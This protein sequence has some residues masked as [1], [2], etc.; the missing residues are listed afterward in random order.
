M[1][2]AARATALVPCRCTD[3]YTRLQIRLEVGTPLPAVV[4]CPPCLAARVTRVAPRR[5]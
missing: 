1:A 4:L 3:C 2:R 5:P